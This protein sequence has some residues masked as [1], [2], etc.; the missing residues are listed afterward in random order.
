[1][2]GQVRGHTGKGAAPALPACPG[3]CAKMG[4]APSSKVGDTEAQRETGSSA[5]APQS[6][7]APGSP[8][9]IWGFLGPV[10]TSSAEGQEGHLGWGQGAGG[11]AAAHH[12]SGGAGLAEAGAPGGCG[13]GGCWLLAP[14]IPP[15]TPGENPG[16]LP[17]REVHGCASSF[18]P[19]GS[20]LSPPPHSG[21]PCP[22]PLFL[23][24][25]RP[26]GPLPGLSTCEWS[27]DTG[28]LFGLGGFCCVEL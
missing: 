6:P 26:E 23:A 10:P 16:Q 11:E 21:P 27:V 4:C 8:S 25:P 24:L 2:S 22:P 9:Q 1:M 20:P 28:S 15:A 13:P 17:P 12:R 19:R 3:Y 5:H 7:R 14:F 18:P